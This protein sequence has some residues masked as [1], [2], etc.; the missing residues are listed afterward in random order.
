MG[1][2]TGKGRS[3]GDQEIRQNIDYKRHPAII[4]DSQTKQWSLIGVGQFK[5]EMLKG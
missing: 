2:G 4:P 1:Q 5:E 3:R